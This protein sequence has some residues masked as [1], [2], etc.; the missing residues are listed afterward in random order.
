MVALV[1]QGV[2]E[3]LADAGEF[4]LAVEA[5]D[6]PEEAV[7]LRA[8]HALAEDKDVLGQQLSCSRSASGRGRGAGSWLTR[9]TN[10]FFRFMVSI[11]SNIASHSCGLMPS[12]EI[13]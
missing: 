10:S 1:P 5:Q 7:E 3:H 11:C 4:V 6:H 13:M 12:E 8:L 2:A 9:V